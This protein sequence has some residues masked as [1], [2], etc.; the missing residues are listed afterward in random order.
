MLVLLIE[1]SVHPCWDVQDPDQ[2]LVEKS[3]RSCRDPQDPNK[4]R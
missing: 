2:V 4:K 1:I 3:M